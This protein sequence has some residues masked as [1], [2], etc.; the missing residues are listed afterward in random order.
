MKRYG[1]KYGIWKSP[2][3]PPTLVIPNFMTTAT[4]DSTVGVVNMDLPTSQFP[5][6]AWQANKEYVQAFLQEAKSLISRVKEGIY[7]E[8]G[9]GTLDVPSTMEQN[10][11]IKQRLELFQVHIADRIDVNENGA[12][13]DKQ[14]NKRRHVEE[15]NDNLIIPAIAYLNTVCV[16]SLLLSSR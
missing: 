8:Y 4:Q 9:Y 10:K 15:E 16:Q 3:Y 5:P 13:L 12:A 6:S 1:E 2:Y 14:Y 11:L 7:E